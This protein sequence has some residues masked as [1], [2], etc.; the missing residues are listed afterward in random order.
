MLEVFINS[1]LFLREVYPSPI[2]RRRKMYNMAVYISTYPK[3]NDYITN[4]LSAAHQLRKLGKLQKVEL[5]IYKSNSSDSF[6]P[7]EKYFFD[8]DCSTSAM[9]GNVTG[10]IAN[11]TSN[12][13]YLIEFENIVR[14]S[15]IQLEQMTKKLKPIE[16]RDDEDCNF[17]IELHTTESG[18]VELTN[19][20][21]SKHEVSIKSFV[22][23][24]MF[25]Y[26]LDLIFAGIQ[27][28]T[29]K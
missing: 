25:T 24:D 3:L 11:G 16:C 28:E 1:I 20:I 9:N 4:V 21:N 27:L 12:D 22:S 23:F 6:C 26:S 17:K 14:N 19:K 5:I 29:D 10:S 8:V 7:L 18:F 15:L 2:F 13:Q